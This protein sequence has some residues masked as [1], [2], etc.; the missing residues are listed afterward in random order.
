MPVEHPAVR[1]HGEQVIAVERDGSTGRFEDSAVRCAEGAVVD[2]GLAD[3]QGAGQAIRALDDLDDSA[4][5][6]EVGEGGL[7][8]LGCRDRVLDRQ[9]R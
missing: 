1:C 8:G 9:R 5:L 4:G 3:R 2:Q 7:P 6:A